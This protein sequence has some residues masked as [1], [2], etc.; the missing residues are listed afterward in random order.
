MFIGHY[1]LGFAA[2]RAA[3]A[4]SLGALFAACQFADLLWP[5][6]VLLGVEHVEVVPGATVVTP[7]AFTFYP[8]SH[9]LL[10]VI[11]WAALFG[12]GYRAVRHSGPAA[13]LVLGALVVSHWVL[14]FTTHRPDLPL[15]FGEPRVGLGLW[16]SFAGTIAVEGTLF[17]AGVAVY[18]RATRAR[19]R[20]GT[21]ALWAMIAFLALAH[22]A[23]LA[24]PPPPSAIA[25]AWSAQALWILAL[26]GWWVD[27]H[28]EPRVQA[29]AAEAAA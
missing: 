14:D 28:R 3:P 7:L 13:A 26:W 23:N 22:A 21:I 12:L 27:R 6:L 10:A 25:V 1:A 2:K 19:D 18:L 16:N 29:R 9:S 11:V 17:V 5:T 15:V 4:V 20:T 24:G 8:Y